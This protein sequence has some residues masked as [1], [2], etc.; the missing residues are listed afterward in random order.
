MDNVQWKKNRI[1]EMIKEG[2]G[3]GNPHKFP[4]NAEGAND[5]YALQ[6]AVQYI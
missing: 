6:V 5:T 3:F 4:P 1:E 2:H